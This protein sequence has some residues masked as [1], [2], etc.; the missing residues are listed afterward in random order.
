MNRATENLRNLSRGSIIIDAE[1]NILGFT[2]LSNYSLPKVT[3]QK[4]IN[5]VLGESFKDKFEEYLEKV[6]KTGRKVSFKLDRERL[7]I[8]PFKN[9]KDK[10]FLISILNDPDQSEAGDQIEIYVNT[11]RNN[12]IELDAEIN[13]IL[14]FLKK[15][16]P[17]TL[18]SRA[19]LEKMVENY[20]GLF[21]LKD[22]ENRVI[23]HNQLYSELIKK[24]RK[25]TFLQ[26]ENSILT[27]K[28]G[29]LFSKIRDYISKTGSNV[30][31]RNLGESINTS[32][33][34]SGDYFEFPVMDQYRNIW[35]YAG[36]TLKDQ[37]I[38]ANKYF[39]LEKSYSKINKSII[40]LDNKHRIIFINDDAKELIGDISSRRNGPEAIF[41]EENVKIF[42]KY[43]SGGKNFNSENLTIDFRSASGK[44][45]IGII[46]LIKDENGNSLGSQIIIEEIDNFTK[47]EEVR[48]MY[49]IIMQTSPEAIFIYDAENLKFLEV[50]DAAL[51]LYGYHREEFLQMD[52]T[53]LYSPEDIQ[54]L[55]ESSNLQTSEG[56]FTGPWKHMK[57]DGKSVL[58]EISKITTEYKGRRALYNIVRDVT[59][60]VALEKEIQIYKSVYENTNDILVLT[61][62][63]G[64]VINMNNNALSFFGFTHQEAERLSVLSL[65]SDAD[66]V[67]FNNAV[68]KSGKKNK[69]TNN[70]ELKK[71]SGETV[72]AD[73]V[74]KPV[75]NYKGEIESF[76]FVFKPVEK[77]L[78][79]EVQ[80]GTALKETHE[81]TSG[82]ELDSAFL[83]HLF[84]EILT[85]INVIIGFGQEL[86]ES[87]DNPTPEQ[88]ESSAII[89]E[90]QKS[91]L[92]LLDNAS[93]YA[94]LVQSKVNPK[95]EKIVFVDLIEP[96]ES[97]TKQ[98]CKQKNV[99][100]SYGKISSSLTFENDKSRF[101]T[102]IN[103]FLTFA[104]QI[105]RENKIFLSAQP[106]NDHSFIVSVKD[107]PY[108]ISEVLLRGLTETLTVDENLIRQRYGFS[109]F[110]VRLF[111]KLLAFVNSRLEIISKNNQPSEIGCVI[112]YEYS[113]PVAE[114]KVSE[115]T[116]ALPKPIAKPS[117]ES[118]AKA[119][120]IQR[121]A[122][123][124]QYDSQPAA[125]VSPP[126]PQRQN[127][128]HPPQPAP[129]VNT[130]PPMPP[131]TLRATKQDYSPPAVNRPAQEPAAAGQATLDLT[132]YSCLYVEDQVDS[133]I[134]FRVQMK[135]LHFIEFADSLE[136]ALPL[137]QANKFNF[138]VMD[139]N[140]QG[141]YNGLDALRIIR[142]LPG[143][144]NVPIIAVTAYVLPGDKEKFIAAGF[145]DF[146]SKPVL[147]DNLTK[148]LRG[149]FQKG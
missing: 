91:L 125:P 35:A 134:L 14:N 109:R 128:N 139:M 56:F 42:D 3:R 19:R 61:N 119:Q 67:N 20:K 141:E 81:N 146:I 116:R 15:N 135:D 78:I 33:K 59:D 23:L 58:V 147:R 124:Q 115:A 99:E 103:T 122:L 148:S 65:I 73:I 17:L 101:Q 127:Y 10:L 41:G 40:L 7:E 83:S 71:K 106:F 108:G 72:K 39:L 26:D 130:Q 87:I 138:I 133:Q 38:K 66:R 74:S 18:L 50:N 113:G 132:S 123:N 84:H 142:R 104:V 143:Y 75:F 4:N 111:R 140:I 118:S 79:K 21:R 145:S 64:F 51:K 88:K 43:F 95:P 77:P 136:K 13:K 8:I 90:N 55:I 28:A 53:D 52:L 76:S 98:I 131:E 44:Q 100:F 62:S 112:D 117:S 46:E 32:V 34:L 27:E 60:K 89:Q 110:S 1:K 11:G 63:D 94:S 82:N 45:L 126:E 102:L 69:L 137:I 24:N 37:E 47:N 29:A 93:E 49:D 54:T 5:E 9:Q 12:G 149:I 48:P 68:Y 96:F 16:F 80:S 129:P 25:N 36:F 85:P 31:I 6:R 120:P 121:P 2:G 86:S 30:L 105:T 114:I 92:Q 70:F 107:S 22:N 97:G 57:K 144:E